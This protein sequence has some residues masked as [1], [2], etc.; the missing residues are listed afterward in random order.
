MSIHNR[1]ALSGVFAA[2]IFLGACSSPPVTPPTV[3]KV[4]T[5]APTTPVPAVGAAA[6]Q[7]TP[8]VAMTG[9]AIPPYLDPKSALFKERSVYFDFDQSNIKPSYTQELELHGKFLAT[10]P[11]VAIK[12]QGNA[13]EQGSAEYNLALGQKRAQAVLT[14]LKLYGVKDTQMEAISYGKEKPRALG[15]DETAYAQNR[16]ADLAYPSN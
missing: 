10:H 7:P 13:D 4:A 1:F 14:T 5:V 15:H 2:T 3:A 12:I 11:T 16:R 8:A 9:T 6:A